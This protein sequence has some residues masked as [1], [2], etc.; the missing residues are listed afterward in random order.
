VKIPPSTTSRSSVIKRLD[1]L[2][3]LLGIG[4][5]ITIITRYQMPFRLDDVIYIQWAKAHSFWDAFDIQRGEIFLTFRPVMGMTMWL[6]AHI[7]GTEQ[8]WIWHLVLAGSFVTAIA[9]SGLTARLISERSSSLYI[10]AVWYPIAFLSI[11]NVLFW[12]AD[13]TYS[14]EMMFVSMAW[15]F[16]MRSLIE[17]RQ[18]MWI[19]ANCIAIIAALTKEPSILLIHGVW[20]GSIFFLR[21][22]LWVQFRQT[23]RSSILLC[24]GS[25]IL[26]FS[27][28]LKMLLTSQ[29]TATRFFHIGDLSSS[30]LAFFIS[31][32]IRYY[33]DTIVTIPFLALLSLS[34]I[35]LITELRYSITTRRNICILLSLLAITLFI[36]SKPVLFLYFL[37]AIPVLALLIG[38]ERRSI[39]FSFGVIGL[40]NSAVLLITIMLVKTQTVELTF[41]LIILG[42]SGASIFLE[43]LITFSAKNSTFRITTISLASLGVITILIGL[44]PK[45]KAKEKL[46][47]DVKESRTNSNDAIK[48]MAKQLPANSTVLVTAPSLFGIGNA[49]DIT[50]LD[51]EYKL[52]AQPTFL[53]GFVRIY[54]DILNRSDLSVGY[55]EDTIMLSR[56]LDSSRAMSNHYLFLQTG[57]D[58][59][60]FHRTINNQKPIKKTDSLL[61]TIGSN[62]RTEI[63]KLR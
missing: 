26:S 53:Q 29:A 10:T 23:K 12:Y 3:L 35:G 50:G 22:E 36:V 38:K 43:K 47:S 59:D 61:T 6:L 19:A 45:L 7:A 14:L 21:K 8:Y 25:Y 42:A 62:Y 28:S 1:V 63:W 48:W 24:V 34:I 60:R 55:L 56:T 32:R 27:I 54:F 40:I 18:A 15:Y 41:L 30:Q 39:L 20:V 17:R 16:G 11:L 9:F 31:D 13:L 2:F 49:N 51:D 4:T 37:L 57:M 52:Y 5:V 46:L 33:S 58:A 44:F